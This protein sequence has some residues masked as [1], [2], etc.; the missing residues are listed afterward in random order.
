MSA[1]ELPV[2]YKAACMWAMRGLR[3]LPVEHHSREAM[4]EKWPE[5]ASNAAS[6]VDRRFA[7]GDVNIGLCCGPQENGWSLLAVDIDPQSGGKETWAALVAE[8]GPLP[9][10]YPV[11]TSPSG[12]RHIFFDV[13][14]EACVTGT[15]TL[16]QGIDTRGGRV[17]GDRRVG[18]GYVLLP[19]SVAAS[20]AEATLGELVSYGAQP[21]RSLLDLAPGP[22]P[23][24]LLDMLVRPVEVE[25]SARRHPSAGRPLLDESSAAEFVRSTYSW[26]EALLKHGWS[27]RDGRYWTRP[28]K[29]VRDGHSAELHD[30]GRLAIWTGDIPDEIRRLGAKQI[31][32]GVS[33]SLFSFIAAYEHG[34]D[35]SEFGRVVRAVMPPSP[36]LFVAGAGTVDPTTTA[37]PEDTH[38][39]ELVYARPWAAS[40]RRS[41]IAQLAG[42][43]VTLINVLIR[44]ATMIPPSYRLPAVIGGM[45]TF[46]LIGCSVAATSVGKS[47]GNEVARNLLTSTNELILWDQ[48]NPSGEGI[49]QAFLGPE[50]EPDA[51]G[52]LKSTGK[53][54]VVRQALHVLVDEAMAFVKQTE[55]SGATILP[56]LNTAWSGGT[57]GQLNA[58]QE[59]RRIVPGGRCRVTAMLNIQESN[60]W[61][62]FDD[63]MTGVGF[64]GRLIFVRATNPEAPDLDDM[65]DWEGALTFPN[66]P[67]IT[68]QFTVLSYDPAIVREI[69]EKRLAT[70]RGQTV[71][72]VASHSMLVRCKIAGIFALFDGR[73]DVT[74]DDWAIAGAIVNTSNAVL[75]RLQRVRVQH[76]RDHGH[77]LAVLRG[78]MA[79]V[80]ED[81]RER[82][83]IARLSDT[84]VASCSKEW[85]GR[86]VMR[87]MRCSKETTHRFNP[88]VLLAVARG[89]LED[90]GQRIRLT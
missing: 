83:A 59:N 76:E 30:D 54:I 79:E 10:P 26:D 20:K 3:I 88:A 78:E 60:S 24:W 1:E 48:P 84:I 45:A 81:T 23:A 75:R 15:N 67:I 72:E 47:I 28:G 19:P 38:F 86:N 7:G 53:L 22:A 4:L 31:D 69:R 62:L 8:H 85:I 71:D 56:T 66:L 73:L 65:P 70:L 51:K 2:M 36:R 18:C 6:D 89:A 90:D 87:K 34:G 37:E 25:R 17:E 29:S 16:G 49:A 40:L 9:T 13:P 41:A 5:N 35:M 74:L 46:D 58:K 39:P 63:K 77:N 33:I 68:N 14:P 11:H 82:K 12:G 21:G 27:T 55:R 80:M 42:P 44:A 43:D 61:Q 52:V 50:M 57:L 64:T 32:G